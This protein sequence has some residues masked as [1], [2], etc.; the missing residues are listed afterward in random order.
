MLR[1]ST[2]RVNDHCPG[3]LRTPASGHTRFVSM[4][5][6]A[7][8]PFQSSIEVENPLTSAVDIEDGVAVAI[9]AG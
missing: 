3:C 8:I 5:H 9:Q 2:A 7:E 6:F 1:K 4:R